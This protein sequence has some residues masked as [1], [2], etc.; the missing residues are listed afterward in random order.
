ME[1]AGVFGAVDAVRA[2]GGK[3]RFTPLNFVAVPLD[4][5]FPGRLGL[6]AKC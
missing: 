5:P 2:A 1:I 6:S 3:C 4:S